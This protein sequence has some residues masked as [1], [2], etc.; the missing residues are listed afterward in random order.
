VPVYAPPSSSGSDSETITINPIG[1]PGCTTEHP[2][3]PLPTFFPIFAAYTGTAVD[4]L[5]PAGCLPLSLP[6]YDNGVCFDVVKGQTYHIAFDGNMG[7]TGT[8]PLCLALTK[9]AINDGFA[10]RIPLHGIYVRATGYNAGATQQPGEP[11]LGDG[12]TGKTVWWSWTAPVSGAVS[13]DLTGS[14]FAFPVAVFTGSSLA[15]LNQVAVGTGSLSFTAVAG[16]TYQI[17]VG[18]DAGLTGA[19]TLVLQAPVVYLDL[20]RPPARFSRFTLLTYTAIS[21]EEVLLEQSAD[22]SHW[23]AMQTL[24]SRQNS[25][26]FMVNKPPAADGPYYQA[27]VVDRLYR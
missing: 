10:H 11:R 20:A 14:D 25:V 16:Q 3:V 4:A 18:D 27:I 9:P 2:L 12:S 8:T 6:G 1:L 23:Q 22:G 13:I 19:I 5:T 21:G 24:L 17:A 7:T 15:S 26:S